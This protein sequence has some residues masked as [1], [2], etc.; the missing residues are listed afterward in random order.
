MITE[1]GVVEQV[2]GGWAWVVTQRISLCA[3][4]SLKKH[5]QL[6]DPRL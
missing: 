4:L 6:N 5:R 3:H 2:E 1:S